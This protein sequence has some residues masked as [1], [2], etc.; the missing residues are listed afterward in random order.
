MADKTVA[1]IYATYFGTSKAPRAIVQSASSDLYHFYCSSDNAII[2]YVKSTDNGSTWGSEVQLIAYDCLAFD[3]WFDQ[4]TPGDSG[5]LIHIWWIRS[6]G[7]DIYY[8]TLDTST[9]TIGTIY[10]AVNGASVINEF[11]AFVSG[12]KSPSGYL[13][14]NY[15]LDS[16]TERGLFRST[17]G[18]ATWGSNLSTTFVEARRDLSVLFPASTTGDGNDIFAA[19]YDA[20]ATELTIKLWDS[21]SATATESSALATGVNFGTSDGTGQGGLSGSIR[22]S[23]GHLIIGIVT[24][25]DTATSDHRIYDVT[26]TSTFAELTAITSNIDDH[27][28]NAVFI[29][30]A[31]NDIYVTYNGKSDGSE[32]IGTA[33]K[34][35][36]ALSTDDGASWSVD[37]TLMQNSAAAVF[38]VWTPLMGDLFIASWRI[39]STLYSNRPIVAHDVA[40]TES[41]TLSEALSAL[42]YENAAMVE[43]MSLGEVVT[44]ARVPQTY[45]VSMAESESLVEVVTGDIVIAGTGQISESV[46]LVATPAAYRNTTSAIAEVLTFTNTLTASASGAPVTSLRSWRIRDWFSAFDAWDSGTTYGVES[47]RYENYVTVSGIN[48]RCILSHSNQTPPNATY[49]E[50][51][52]TVELP[53]S[54]AMLGTDPLY[55]LFRPSDGLTL[56]LD[57]GV[58]KAYASCTTPKDVMTER[59]PDGY[60]GWFDYLLP[61]EAFGLDDI[62]QENAEVYGSINMSVEVAVQ[63]AE[64]V[65][66]LGGL[67]TV[68]NTTL[69][70][71]DVP[72]SSVGGATVDNAAIA[73]AVRVELTTEL[74]RIDVPVS[75]A[76]D[77]ATIAAYVLAAIETAVRADGLTAKQAEIVNDAILHGLVVGAGTNTES[78]WSLNDSLTLV[79][80]VRITSD[81]H[82]NRTVVE[83]INVT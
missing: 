21:S 70:R 63:F 14:C 61:S 79:E 12:C 36:Y 26:N 23:D 68:Q 82:G 5:T 9:D 17:D 58:F 24:E 7:S 48:Y 47:D 81:V 4:W 50:V 20:S 57:D 33:A 78:F 2:S 56:D 10:T 54:L 11:G 22:H 65:E 40:I 60:R 42:R 8:T 72:V 29:D 43:S 30:Q 25:Y 46:T 49:W 34:V 66:Q 75:T 80:R 69:N 13:Y 3:V 77:P 27:Y 67:R 59:D 19:Y 18:G 45:N 76:G 74:A 16:G 73:A 41:V 32:T 28:H 44:G 62:Y 37:N 15:D 38:Q 35:Y 64:G 52:T 39:S 31:T 83:F 6:S 71:V 51:V 53:C 1:S 55:Y